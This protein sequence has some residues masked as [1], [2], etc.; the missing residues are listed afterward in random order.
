MSLSNKITGIIPTFNEETHIEA[1]IDSLDF[2][3]EI[4]VIDSFSS[5]KTIALAEAKGVKIL[6]RKFDNFSSQKNYAIKKASHS[7]I[8]LLDA[9]ERVTPE[10]QKEVLETVNKSSKYTAYWIWRSNF[11]MKRRIKYSGWQNDK[12]IRLFK[13]D[14]CSYDGKLV[15]E[16]IQSTGEIG[17]LKQVLDHYTYN[18]FNRFIQKK[19]LYAELQA[20]ELSNRGI[21]PTL[22]HFIFKPAYRFINH[23]ILRRGFLDGI[24]GFFI[25]TFS[26]Y[27]IFARYVNLWLINKGL[28]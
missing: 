19:N 1:A 23:Y 22:A 26:A 18:N 28:K 10:L 7:W 25:A 11:F 4:I 15:H 13:R 12:V 17:R 3:D 6:Q 9:D 8:F 20:K 5:D 16:E 24:E 2:T 27:A 21:K 14:K